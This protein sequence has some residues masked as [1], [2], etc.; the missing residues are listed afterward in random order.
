MRYYDTAIRNEIHEQNPEKVPSTAIPMTDARVSA[1]FQE[2]PPNHELT[3]DSNNLPI[4][5]EIPPLTAE[6][7]FE[8]SISELRSKRNNLLAQTDYL[9]LSDQTMT[10]E[11]TDYRQALR[12][13]TNGLTTVEDVEAV[14]FPERPEA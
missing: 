9:A 1:F 10:A 12:D 7:E 5:S 14:E 6:Q 3:F 8:I 4:I 2:L 11:M 13:I